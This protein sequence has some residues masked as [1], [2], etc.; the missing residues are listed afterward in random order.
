[1]QHDPEI[2]H[3]KADALLVLGSG[4]EAALAYEQWIGQ[5]KCAGFYRNWPG[6]PR[7]G[8]PLVLLM[9]KD[10]NDACA[11]LAPE[12]RVRLETLQR[13][14]GHPNNLPRKNYE[15]SPKDIN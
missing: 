4:K 13:L 11:A 9:P 12:L 2:L 6:E 1:V 10:T 7:R 5:G 3:L 8:H 14:F 15:T